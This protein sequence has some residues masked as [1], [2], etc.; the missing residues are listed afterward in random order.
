MVTYPYDIPS[1]IQ[2]YRFDDTDPLAYDEAGK[3]FLDQAGYGAM[4]D[5]V[6]GN[7][8]PVFGE[9]DGHRGLRLDNTFH[10]ACPMPIPWQGAAI[11]VAKIELLTTGT[12][13]KYPMIFGDNGTVTSNGNLFAQH[14]SGTRS[15]SMATTGA[16]LTAATALNSD[17]LRVAGY[18]FDQ[19]T[20]KAHATLDGVTVTEVQ[21]PASSTNGNAVA[22]SSA[23]TGLRF[24]QLKGVAGDY[25]VETGMIVWMFEA[26]FFAENIWL[27]NAQTAAD[28]MASL[29][30]KYSI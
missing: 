6:I 10:G 16:Q 28:L 19:E 4:A 24:G 23:Q 3:R 21:A 12:L 30:D 17:A 27:T 29:R 14:F 15:L 26:H 22:L 7:G 1:Y 18:A 25:S 20:R 11:I 9:V 2:G 13:K 5:L 8:A